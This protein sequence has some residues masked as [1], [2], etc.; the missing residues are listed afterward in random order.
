MYHRNVGVYALCPWLLLTDG[1][2]YISGEVPSFTTS[3]GVYRAFHFGPWCRMWVQTQ[4]LLHMGLIKGALFTDWLLLFTILSFYGT[5][6]FKIMMMATWSYGFAYDYLEACL[7]GVLSNGHV[8][9][10]EFSQELQFFCAFK[11]SVWTQAKH[12]SFGCGFGPGHTSSVMVP[13]HW[14]SFMLISRYQTSQ[15]AE[16]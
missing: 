7:S 1:G 5:W 9:P 12:G 4:A 6:M 2:L 8:R 11:K 15:I 10:Q 13:R 3:E 16:F 14:L